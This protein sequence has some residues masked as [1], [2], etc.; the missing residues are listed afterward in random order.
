MDF[1]FG[2]ELHAAILFRASEKKTRGAGNPESEQIAIA[3]G[4]FF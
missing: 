4:F 2:K 1:F 3:V